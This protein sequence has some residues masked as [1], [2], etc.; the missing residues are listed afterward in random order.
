MKLLLVCI[1]GYLKTI[2]A[3]V[4]VLFVLALVVAAVW[5]KT[6]DMQYIAVFQ[7]WLSLLGGSKT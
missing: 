7:Y 3:T 5:A 6:M 2:F 1:G 4:G